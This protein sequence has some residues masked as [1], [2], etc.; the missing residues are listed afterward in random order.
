MSEQLIGA[1]A[2]CF[3]MDESQFQELR[4]GYIGLW[5]GTTKSAFLAD[6]AAS[7][8]VEHDHGDRPERGDF[9][10]EDSWLIAIESWDEASGISYSRFCADVD[11]IHTEQPDSLIAFQVV[12]AGEGSEELIQ[13]LAEFLFPWSHEDYSIEA[14][15][16]MAVQRLASGDDDDSEDDGDVSEDE[17]GFLY[18][19][20]PDLPADYGMR[21]DLQHG[22]WIIRDTFGAVFL[23]TGPCDDED[24]VWSALWTD[25][26]RWFA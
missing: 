10:D 14:V 2:A 19:L 24:G 11:A 21:A 12:V 20:D 25:A 15:L 6:D 26:G 17:D 9:A 5:D 16:R 23:P 1:L 22:S 7:W 13:S 3:G 8:L 4:C 18:G